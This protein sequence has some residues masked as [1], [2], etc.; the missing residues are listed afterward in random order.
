MNDNGISF[1]FDPSK[2]HTTDMGIERIRRNLRLPADTDPVAF[3]RELICA[4]DSRIYR[5]G[6]NFYCEKDGARITVNAG[7]LTI[8]TAKSDKN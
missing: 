6:K 4:E 1:P 3:C 5:Q 8:I 2:L 7:S